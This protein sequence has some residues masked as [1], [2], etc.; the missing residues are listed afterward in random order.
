M[1]KALSVLAV[2]LLAALP[3]G[4]ADS[5][6]FTPG[7]TSVTVTLQNYPNAFEPVCQPTRIRVNDRTPVVLRL[8]NLSPVEICTPAT[9]A[10]TPT[11]VTNPLESIINSVTGLKAFDFAQ[12]IGSAEYLQ[13]MIKL[14][15]LLG[16]QPRTA[17]VQPPPPAPPKAG[18]TP[19]EKALRLFNQIAGQVLQSAQN[20]TRKQALWA[21]KYK[22]D[23][24][25]MISYLVADY[26]GANYS[27]FDPDLDPLLVNVRAHIATS[28][29]ASDAYSDAYP[30]NE[31]DYADLQM[32]IDQMKSLQGRLITNCTTAAKPCNEDILHTTARLIDQA[33]AFMSIIQDN[34]KTLQGMQTALV[35]SFAVLHKVEVD[36]R[37][38][39]NAGQIKTV[40]GVLVQ[41]FHL[42]SD[43]SATDT[44]SI[45]CSSDTTPAVATTDTINY[46]IT[47][48]NVPAFTVSGGLLTTFL[49]KNVYGVTQHL[50]TTTTPPSTVSVFAITDSA[51][52]SVFPMAYVNYRTGKPALRTWWGEPN[53]EL[54]IANNVSTGIGINPNTGT[55]QVEFFLGDAVSFSRVLVHAGL[56][57]GR[58]ESL[59]GGF[60]LG[61]VPSGFS[62]TA[63]PL[64]WAYHPAFAIGLSVRIAPF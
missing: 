59:G 47:F 46:S 18:E 21:G 5:C 22:S 61:K 20:V 19:D 31:L 41:D 43:Y 53:N 37:N 1:L 25:A 64:N 30:P 6:K 36:Y 39:L 33:N 40:G 9:K 44:G 17:A 55:N 54:I 60:S 57:F 27:N 28:S 23:N 52:A 49:Q 11:A 51:R 13:D 35:T 62:G 7:Q 2:L 10:P 38:R 15:E 29:I 26:R 32:L 50:D 16:I 58:T 56:H 63:A 34:F 48:Q 14:D 3:A 8:E 45:S 4:A 12:H 42:G 24:D